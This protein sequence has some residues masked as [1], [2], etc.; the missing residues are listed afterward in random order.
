MIRHIALFKLHPGVS[1]DDPR[2]RT[3]LRFAYGVGAN[4]PHLSSWYAG[5]NI[6]SRAAAYDFAIIG[7]VDDEHGLDAYLNHPYHLQAVDHW[8]AISDWIVADVIEEEAHTMH[9][10]PVGGGSTS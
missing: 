10:D 2:M 4:V 3:A 1:W 6:S 9:R 8:R 5:R 7:T